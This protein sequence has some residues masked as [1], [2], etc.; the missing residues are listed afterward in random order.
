MNQSSIKPTKSLESNEPIELNKGYY[1][2]QEIDKIHQIIKAFYLLE[3]QNKKLKE[4]I[5]TLEQALELQKKQN[6]SF[7]LTKEELTKYLYQILLLA[8]VMHSFSIVT[9]VWIMPFLQT[10]KTLA[11]ASVVQNLPTAEVAAAAIVSKIPSFYR[12]TNLASMAV[13][14]GAAGKLAQLSYSCTD[15]SVKKIISVIFSFISFGYSK[16]KFR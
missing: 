6:N 8:L 2:Q 3:Q 12:M 14:Q 5:R 10:K 16:I 1:S 7:L 13:R 9:N 11:A 15:A 4:I